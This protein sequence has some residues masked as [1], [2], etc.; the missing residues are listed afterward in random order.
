MPAP[1]F[2]YRATIR[3]LRFCPCVP[4][5]IVSEVGAWFQKRRPPT[6]PTP[7]PSVAEFALAIVSLKSSP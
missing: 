6:M 2:S 3:S 5:W 7:V 1:V 4:L